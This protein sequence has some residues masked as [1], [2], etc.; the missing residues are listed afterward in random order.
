[1]A[2]VPPLPWRCLRCG[3]RR[4]FTVR[5]DDPEEGPVVTLDPPCPTYVDCERNGVG[6]LHEPNETCPGHEG[7]PWC[8]LDGRDD[9]A[10]GDLGGVLAS[11]SAYKRGRADAALKKQYEA[12][13][14]AI[15]DEHETWHKVWSGEGRNGVAPPIT[16]C[17]NPVCVR[18]SASPG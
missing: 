13:T 11:V 8:P 9:Y 15:E 2:E 14:L 18:V 16:E 1:M 6:D 10:T 3:E 12:L 17:R 4:M 5:F 7:S